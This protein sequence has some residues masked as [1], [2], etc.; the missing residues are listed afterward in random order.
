MSL[1]K[2]CEN[3]ARNADSIYQNFLD[4]LP[5]Q[6]TP[7]DAYVLAATTRDK[8]L[9]PGYN[10]NLREVY[11]RANAFKAVHIGGGIGVGGVVT[12][13]AIIIAAPALGPVA[14]MPIIFGPVLGGMWAGIGGDGHKKKSIMAL[15]QSR[16]MV[17]AVCDKITAMDKILLQTM[18]DAYKAA[19]E[20]VYAAHKG[21][22]ED[23]IKQTPPKLNKLFERRATNEMVKTFKT[24]VEKPQLP[25]A[26]KPQP[27]S[28]LAELDRKPK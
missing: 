8:L 16:K 23:V 3:A 24:A 13:T 20:D 21:M 7:Q 15:G 2:H 9:N 6:K 12:G 1:A 18:R 10:S 17:A 4:Q 25:P 27:P 5:K 28:I 11:K 14:I 19:P 26:L 22:P